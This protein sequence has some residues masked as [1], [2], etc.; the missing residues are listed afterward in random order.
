MGMT[1]VATAALKPASSGA[2]STNSTA[3]D[4]SGFVVNI[5]GGTA[6]SSKTQLPTAAQTLGAAGAAAGSLLSNPIFIIALGV[7]VFLL[8]K[9]KK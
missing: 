9:H 3:Y 5:G 1:S 6:N 8:L 2:T 4:N 7:G